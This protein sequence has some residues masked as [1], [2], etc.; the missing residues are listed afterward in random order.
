MA[1]VVFYFQVHQPYR[2]KPYSMFL[3]GEDR[4]YFVGSDSDKLNNRQI[5]RKVA[6]KCYLPTNELLLRLLEKYSEFKV[7]FSISGMAMEQFD[8]FAPEVLGSFKKLVETGRVELLTETYYHSLA[9]LKS[10]KE[11]KRQVEKHQMKMEEAFGVKPKVLRNTELLYNN[12]LARVAEEMGFEV[13]LAEG[14]DRHLGW[15]SPNFVYKPKGVEKIKLLLKNYRLSDD[16]AFRF[17]RKDWEGW[18]LTAEKFATWIDRA[19]GEVVNLFMDYETYG[20]HQWADTGIFEFLEELPDV[21]LAHGHDFMS[22]SEAAARHVVMDEIDMPNL[23]SWADLERD[24]SAWTANPMQ[25]TALRALF[26]LEDKVMESEDKQLIDDWRKLTTS[27]HFYYMSTKWDT[28]GD[29]H[30]Y[31]SPNNSPFEAY[32]NFMNVLHDMRIRCYS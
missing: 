28:D 12:D 10:P 2:I 24:T 22:V 30:K 25:V 1:S 3:I 7:S 6:D 31:F 9:F 19:G 16:I 29:V 4:A 13:V 27:D 32:T 21:L 18:P 20:E 17:S 15:R 8:E 14:V 5:L 11:F 23:T 26:E